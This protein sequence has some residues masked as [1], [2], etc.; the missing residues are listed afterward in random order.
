MP[1]SGWC[2]AADVR[3]RVRQATAAATAVWD[4]TAIE[5]RITRA[6]NTL[7]GKLVGLFGYTTISGWLTACPAVMVD[8]CAD[9]AAV[10]VL[11]D[12]HGEA[13]TQPGKPGERLQARVD[14]ALADILASKV[15]LLDSV[16]TAVPTV[17]D[18]V[19]STTREKEPTFSMG[20]QVL[21]DTQRGTLDDY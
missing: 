5:L 3:Y 9:Q 19:E 10:Y 4:D 2:D 1:W 17:C 12:W 8:I 20:E 16:G 15:T 21:D 18:L 14:A 13:Q 11:T 6:Q 7:T